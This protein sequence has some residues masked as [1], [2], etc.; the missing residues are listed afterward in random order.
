MPGLAVSV[1]DTFGKRVCEAL[2][3]ATSSGSTE[4]LVGSNDVASCTFYG[5][6][7]R[8]GTFAIKASAGSA[9]GSVEGIKVG[10]DVC[11]VAT[12]ST[13]ISLKG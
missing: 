8:R 7:E 1:V 2:V 3:T 13:T 10:G 5:A 12:V 6:Y 4:T 11:H 9:T